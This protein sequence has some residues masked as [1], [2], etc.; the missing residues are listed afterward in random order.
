MNDEH[1]DVVL[2]KISCRAELYIKYIDLLKQLSLATLVVLLIK[3]G[4]KKL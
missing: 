3:K 4:V 2:G 1:F